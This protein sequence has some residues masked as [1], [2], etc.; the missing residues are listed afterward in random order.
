MSKIII[1][2]VD[3]LQKLLTKKE[4]GGLIDFMMKSK[5][6]KITGVFAVSYT[7]LDVYKRQLL[8]FLMLRNVKECAYAWPH[9]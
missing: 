2:I 1:N 8:Q 6:V 3:E 9:R 7:H 4:K 5:T